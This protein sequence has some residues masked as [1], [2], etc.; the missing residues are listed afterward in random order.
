MESVL[1]G[2]I[3]FVGVF[4]L[5]IFAA[6]YSALIIAHLIPEKY[7]IYIGA[8]LGFIFACIVAVLEIL[9]DKEENNVPENDENKPPPTESISQSFLYQ[10]NSIINIPDS[11]INKNHNFYLYTGHTTDNKVTL[12]KSDCVEDTTSGY[13]FS[14]CANGSYYLISEEDNPQNRLLGHDG[15]DLREKATKHQKEASQLSDDM[16]IKLMILSDNIPPLEM[17]VNHHDGKFSHH[18]NAETQS[19]SSLRQ[20]QDKW[21]KVPFFGKLHIPDVGC[22][23]HNSF[24]MTQISYHR[25]WKDHHYQK[26]NDY[27]IH[28][29]ASQKK[30]TKL[31]AN[32]QELNAARAKLDSQM[33]RLD[34]EQILAASAQLDKGEL[35]LSADQLG[36]GVHWVNEY[37]VKRTF[38]SDL[39]NSQSGDASYL[40]SIDCP[41]NPQICQTMQVND[42]E[43]PVVFQQGISPVRILN[44][45]I[46]YKNFQS[47]RWEWQISDFKAMASSDFAL[48]LSVYYD[49]SEQASGPGS[50]AQDSQIITH[51]TFNHFKH[52]GALK[53]RW[54]RENMEANQWE[55][56]RWQRVE[57]PEQDGL[58]FEE[59]S[60]FLFPIGIRGVGYHN[61]I[62]PSRLIDM[63]LVDLNEDGLDDVLSV[64]SDKSKTK[65]R[66][67]DLID[68]EK[69]SPN[70]EKV[71]TIPGVVNID[72]VQLVSGTHHVDNR[73]DGVN[74]LLLHSK[75]DQK[76]Y[77]VAIIQPMGADLRQPDSAFDALR[78][79][80]VEHPISNVLA[81]N[82][83]WYGDPLIDN[84][85]DKSQVILSW[86]DG[87]DSD[88]IYVD[89]KQLVIQHQ[90]YSLTSSNSVNGAKS[91]QLQT[92]G[93]KVAFRSEN[94]KRLENPECTQ[95]STYSYGG[96]LSL[97]LINP[98]DSTDDQLGAV[99]STTDRC[100]LIRAMD[101]YHRGK[102]DRLLVR[103]HRDQLSA[104]LNS[105]ASSSI[106]D[107]PFEFY[108]D[109]TSGTYKASKARSSLESAAYQ[110]PLSKTLQSQNLSFDETDERY[111]RQKM[112]RDYCVKENID[113]K[114][115]LHQW[116]K[117]AL[118]TDSD[119]S[120][121]SGCDSHTALNT[122]MI[123]CIRTIVLAKLD[124]LSDGTSLESST[125]KFRFS[126]DGEKS[127]LK[128]TNLSTEN[129][130]HINVNKLF[131]HLSDT[132][133]LTQQ[134][135]SNQLNNP[136]LKQPIWA[137]LVASMINKF[138][139]S[140][141]AGAEIAACLA[142][143]PLAIE[144]A[145]VDLIFTVAVVAFAASKT[146]EWGAGGLAGDYICS[147]DQSSSPTAEQKMAQ[148]TPAPIDSEHK[149]NVFEQS[150]KDHIKDGT[151]G[152]VAGLT[153]AEACS[154]LAEAA[155][156]DP[157]P[158]TKTALAVADGL[159]WISLMVT[160]YLGDKYY[161]YRLDTDNQRLVEHTNHSDNHAGSLISGLSEAVLIR[162]TNE[163][164]AS[165]TADF[166][167]TS[168]SQIKPCEDNTDFCL[169][170]TLRIRVSDN[171]TAEVISLSTGSVIPWWHGQLGKNEITGLPQLS[172][173]I[174]VGN[175]EKILTY[176]VIKKDKQGNS[177][178]GLTSLKRTDHEG[179]QHF[180][181]T[182]NPFGQVISVVS[183]TENASEE[184]DLV[185]SWAWY[186]QPMDDAPQPLLDFVI[187]YDNQDLNGDV[188]MQA[189]EH[190]R[191]QY[192]QQKGHQHQLHE[193]EKI[194]HGK[195]T[196]HLK[197][198]ASASKAK[199][200]AEM[201][202]PCDSNNG[203][204]YAIDQTPS[205]PDI[206]RA[207]A[208]PAMVYEPNISMW[209]PVLGFTVYSDGIK[210]KTLS[211][212]SPSLCPTQYAEINAP[213]NGLWDVTD[214]SQVQMPQPLQ[215]LLSG[216]LE[217][218]KTYFFKGTQIALASIAQL[219]RSAL[220]DGVGKVMEEM[221]N[222]PI[223][224]KNKDG[225]W[226]NMST[227]FNATAGESES[228]EES[229]NQTDSFYQGIA[230][231][232]EQL[233]LQPPQLY[234]PIE[235][236]DK[237]TSVEELAK[238]LCPVSPSPNGDGSPNNDYE[239]GECK[240]KEPGSDEDQ[241][242]TENLQADIPS[243]P[244]DVLMEYVERNPDGFRVGIQR[245]LQEF[246]QEH[247]ELIRA[248][249]SP[250]KFDSKA[251]SR[252]DLPVKYVRGV[253][254]QTK[255]QG[256]LTIAIDIAVDVY[257]TIPQ[258]DGH[259]KIEKAYLDSHTKY[260]YS[261]VNAND[262][263]KGMIVFRPVTA[264][265]APPSAGFLGVF[266]VAD[267]K[268]VAVKCWQN[269]SGQQDGPQE[270][271]QESPRNDNAEP[272]IQYYPTFEAR[273]RNNW[274]LRMFEFDYGYDKKKN[275]VIDILG[276]KDGFKE[277]LV[278][279]QKIIS[280][281][282]TK[283]AFS[284]TRKK[285][286]L[287]ASYIETK[288]DVGIAFKP[289]DDKNKYAQIM[290][291]VSSGV[292]TLIIGPRGMRRQNLLNLQN[293]LILAGITLAIVTEGID[294]A[295]STDLSNSSSLYFQV[296][297]QGVYD[298]QLA[299][300]CDEN[301]FRG[302]FRAGIGI[303]FNIW[304]NL[305]A[306]FTNMP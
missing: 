151:K 144:C 168:N 301:K 172:L 141:H 212:T 285:D 290:Q 63:H 164:I 262:F 8:V 247:P 272:D 173:S 302:E 50:S 161:N 157:E 205:D 187:R 77:L 122:A 51:D 112:L 160:S 133:S 217:R 293:G 27:Q 251:Y 142:L 216:S 242:E 305:H 170:D 184:F 246:E 145:A 134:H 219:N 201:Y 158:S 28:L 84:Q 42:A 220:S 115:C 178:F 125:H 218:A 179:I 208:I 207:Y 103:N 288:V 124:Q 225:Q 56:E 120:E 22:R 83:L 117:N 140:A 210:L 135:T 128:R 69:Q 78:I 223:E 19:Q 76:L 121:Y 196:G 252:A 80:V 185:S 36:P 231:L 33:E 163:G 11:G 66:Y 18:L 71:L 110:Y 107:R 233:G 4:A 38:L 289:I 14:G 24:H 215:E 237:N 96:H 240:F 6:V 283:G 275:V 189:S 244:H 261:F 255:G 169:D 199:P 232:A 75:A 9:N 292:S 127:I 193:I 60:K 224:I 102:S 92:I 54:H 99:V 32:Y 46:K 180:Y 59:N 45:E 52:S 270:L 61:Q 214:F 48:S 213:G 254:D 206:S 274:T 79:V 226:T 284:Q 93:E 30:Y 279:D 221:Q 26:K 286:E 176:D 130:D 258:D 129:T 257:F 108:M 116:L 203:R 147:Q 287:G 57:V 236:I 171:G 89:P 49:T 281:E 194:V 277:N 278:F 266:I 37:K 268:V 235:E 259:M 190:Y 150:I 188:D 181:W 2:A 132:L 265:F 106:S 276:V 123:K 148:H 209:L 109:F 7:W 234:K 303:K 256:K 273:F 88:S 183:G 97:R 228:E 70:Y 21:I 29:S 20:C 23:L 282:R 104:W 100:E 137:D 64:Y 17:A 41:F 119:A 152:F 253:Q 53:G 174:T 34:Q 154:L 198:G 16:S 94:I 156:L 113:D 155:L 192:A 239:E 138:V 175:D 159:C 263:F 43:Y 243:L 114:D 298:H 280:F 10:K 166:S 82:A 98:P 12:V 65:I 143:G 267:Q 25:F 260:G 81:T 269:K 73:Q 211:S 95:S 15:H 162:V 118:E 197:L 241:S 304:G 35:T 294:M 200:L 248:N 300:C 177:I 165:N 55:I 238:L 91:Y 250:L 149:K 90:T 87:N 74:Y 5:I 126:K 202:E 297:V 227:L 230:N 111:L 31:Q 299:S 40:I 58:V 105:D 249:G 182:Y 68:L 131:D 136:A 167:S 85:G 296:G 264:N 47:P 44:A 86:I 222:Q 139:P 146:C 62:R 153:A 3:F 101:P 204:C 291:W 245:F 271:P 1:T 67:R 72:Q 13:E 306:S 229:N 195:V 191:F 186:H 39:E 295:T